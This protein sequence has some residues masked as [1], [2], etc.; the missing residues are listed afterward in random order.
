MPLGRPKG[1]AQRHR[2]PVLIS[3]LRRASGSSIDVELKSSSV[4]FKPNTCLTCSVGAGSCVSW[5]LQEQGAAIDDEHN[6]GNSSHHSGCRW[7]DF[8]L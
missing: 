7:L 5:L 3:V 1:K 8:L 6:S 2:K 4:S